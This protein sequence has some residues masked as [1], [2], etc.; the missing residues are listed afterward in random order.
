MIIEREYS[1]KLSE[2][3]K[4]NKITN[5]AILS[6]LED[7][8]GIHSNI[9]GI[10]LLAINETHLSWVL[11]E[12]KLQV[13]RRPQYTEKLI[14]RTWSKG[15]IRCYAYRDFEILDEQGN[16]VVKA[17]SK[18]VLLNI[19]QEK[20]VRLQDDLMEKYYH[21][22]NKNA[23]GDEDDFPKQKELEQYELETTYIVRRA[24]I[25]MN[26]HMHN[27]NYLDLANEVLPEEIYRTKMFDNVRITYKKEIKLGEKVKC[28]YGREENRHIV[29]IKSEDDKILHALIELS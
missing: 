19:E 9:A 7:V 28:K 6:Y 13:I 24:D 18:W 1:V 3:D 4:N 12:W 21:E 15:Y 25:D 26:N 11:L 10:G 20:I 17:A 5:K 27:L 29:A 23:F 22:W 14:V 2:I 8:G 16:V